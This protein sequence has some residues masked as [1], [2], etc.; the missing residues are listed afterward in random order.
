MPRGIVRT[1]ASAVLV[2][3]SLASVVSALAQGPR[4]QP[5]TLPEGEGKSAVETLCVRCH[6]LDLLNGSGGYRREGWERV[7]G[8]MVAVPR[9]QAAVMAGYLAEHFPEKPRPG[10]VLVPGSTTIS[11]REWL[12]PTL[13]SRPHDPLAAPDGSIWWT[14]QWAN[15]LGRLDPKSGAMKEFPLKT[16]GSAPSPAPVSARVIPACPPIRFCFNTRWD[17]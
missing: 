4:G 16:P 8:S 1:A 17:N 15:V 10:A 5:L 11:I 14:G 13:G 12:A 7:L 9:E 3:M 6:A 2:T